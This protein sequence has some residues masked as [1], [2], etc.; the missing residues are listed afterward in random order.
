MAQS[1]E[2]KKQ[3]NKECY[4]Y[5]KSIGVCVHCHKQKAGKGKVLCGDCAYKDS[6]R[7]EKYRMSVSKEQKRKTQDRNN[8]RNR[9]VREERRQNGLCVI[10]GH[11]LPDDTY[12]TCWECRRK[13]QKY[14]RAKREEKG[15]IS[16]DMRY[17]GLY[18]IRCCKPIKP[19][20]SKLCPD[21]YD[22]NV[23]K[24]ELMRQ[25]PKWRKNI[26]EGYFRQ[27]NNPL[28]EKRDG[29]TL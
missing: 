24:A 21:C 15:S 18:C 28:F 19:N 27:M 23:K 14:Q 8:E 1:L 22:A 13:S 29:V 11:K 26:D 25:S 2:Y 10:C 20:P 5:Y 4:Y 6:E 9:R 12:K 7:G 16:K 3:Y 17:S